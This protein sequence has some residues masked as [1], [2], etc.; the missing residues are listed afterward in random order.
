MFEVALR[1]ADNHNE[2]N[3]QKF[4]FCY[5]TVIRQNGIK[6]NITI[7]LYW[8]R[9]YSYLNLDGRNRQLLLESDETRSIGVSKICDLKQLPDAV[10]Y[11][12]LVEQCKMN[13][14]GNDA[15]YQSFPELSL[16]AWLSTSTEKVIKDKKVSE[17]SF[18]QWFEPL[19][20][21]LK[22]LGG[23]AAPEAARKQIALNL[24]LSDE[25]ID[26]TRGKTEHKKF[27][28]EVAWARNY[29]A[30]EGIIDK[31]IRGIWTLTERGK[32]IAMTREIA[33][34]IFAKWVDIHK[35]RRDKAH[36]TES[37]ER[38]ANEKCYWLYAPG[39]SS[40]KWD[41][42]YTQGIMGLGSDKWNE[43]GDLNQYSCRE[44]IR[45]KMKEMYDE[46]KSYKHSSL[47]FWQFFHDIRDGD[48]VFA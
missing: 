10:T 9:P 33:S 8:I 35:E 45:T 3:R 39:E 4:V 5:D 46:T 48:I 43:L 34:D 26:E 11:L 29:L 14:R 41:E 13:F 7:G 19:I 37:Q 32:N 17:A 15:A 30:Y 2:D 24:N 6:W 18:L 22:D 38:E 44:E 23:S 20:E 31:A 40:S 16:A 36:K 12:R 42:F 47:A 1:F 25:I 28:N 21:A 27:D